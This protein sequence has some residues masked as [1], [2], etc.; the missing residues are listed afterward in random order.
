MNPFV[1]RRRL[2]PPGQVTRTDHKASVERRLGLPLWVPGLFIPLF[3]KLLGLLCCHGNS[4][5]KAGGSS[6][7][8]ALSLHH[9]PFH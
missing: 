6:Y 5:T 7:L 9:R 2:R 1:Q 3:S 4:R 8:L